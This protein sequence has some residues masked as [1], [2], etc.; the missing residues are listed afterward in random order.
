MEKNSVSENNIEINTNIPSD[1]NSN[2]IVSI[3][4]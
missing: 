4:N 2:E 1:I 3:F